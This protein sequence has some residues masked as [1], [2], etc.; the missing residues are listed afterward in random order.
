MRRRLF[1]ERG[2]LLGGRKVCRTP[3]L[4]VMTTALLSSGPL[5][6]Q[7]IQLKDGKTL[8]AKSVRRSGAT[9]MAT[10]DVTGGGAGEVGYPVEKIARIDFPEPAQLKTARD[11]IAQGKSEAAIALLN[12]LLSYHGSF[13]EVPGA[14]WSQAALAKITALQQM[15]RDNEAESLIAELSKFSAD[16]DAAALARVRLA[17]NLARKQQHEKAVEICDQVIREST[18]SQIL[19]ETWTEKAHSLLAL[20]HYD[21]ALLAYLRVPVF[22]E[23]Q[24]HLMPASLLGSARA[25]ARMDDLDHAKEVLH[26]LLK[27]YPA[28]SETSLAR[29]ELLKVEADAA[30]LRPS[31]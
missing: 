5:F 23:D 28:A 1:L 13:R 29:A 22:Y 4:L 19:A 26:E 11:L 21:A 16:P 27:D 12:P 10:I 3:W 9:V 25:Y 31:R 17:A 18:K 30:R 2:C 20:K 15:Q 6:A 14:W 7:T 24:Q 8:I